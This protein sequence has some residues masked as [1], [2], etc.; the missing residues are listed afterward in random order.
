MKF[1]AGLLALVL[2]VAGV[3]AWLVYGSGDDAG[4]EAVDA[5]DSPYWNLS[6][7]HI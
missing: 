2:L 4:Q 5:V 7:I 1:F 6:L 3:V